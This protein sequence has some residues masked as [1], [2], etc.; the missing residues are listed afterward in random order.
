M[1]GFKKN[2]LNM[3]AVMKNMPS[4][5]ESND[6]SKWE[7]DYRKAIGDND[8]ETSEQFKAIELIYEIAGLN[9]FG[10]F[11]AQESENVYKHVISELAKLNIQV[12]ENLDVSEW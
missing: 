3:I 12:S 5:L 6:L 2:H 7:S 4:Y 9:L 1:E 10:E 11:Q 8:D